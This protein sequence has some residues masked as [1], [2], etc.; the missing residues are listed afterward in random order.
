MSEAKPWRNEA[1]GTSGVDKFTNTQSQSLNKPIGRK[2]PH[3]TLKRSLRLGNGDGE[4]FFSETDPKRRVS[5]GKEGCLWLSKPNRE[6]SNAIMGGSSDTIVA[7]ATV[8]SNL[9]SQ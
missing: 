4:V 2:H 1:F 9:L 3:Q 7:R 5:G 8:K 6:K